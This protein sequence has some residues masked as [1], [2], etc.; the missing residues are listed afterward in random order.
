MIE[1]DIPGRGT[2]TV[3]HL[4]L[5]MNGTVALDGDLLPDVQKLIAAL[6]WLVHVVI[7]TADTH[8]GAEDLSRALNVDLHRL[9]PGGE[10]AQKLALVADLGPER[11]MAVGNGTNDAAMLEAS[12][13]GVCVVGREGA[14]T[15]TLLKSDVVVGDV[16][17]ALELLL[18]PNRVTATLRG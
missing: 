9:E 17:H 10:A 4:V 11:T 6:R 12:A 1:V 3:D 16:R 7:V 18:R 14:A 15:E 8:G 5:D 13:L 2:Y